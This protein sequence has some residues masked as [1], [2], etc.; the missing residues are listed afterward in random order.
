VIH[1][2]HRWDLELGHHARGRVGR[3]EHRLQRATLPEDRALG[4]SAKA[5]TFRTYTVIYKITEDL[6]AAMLGMLEP[7]EVEESVGM[8]EVRET[9]RASRIASS[10]AAQRD[11]GKDFEECQMRLVRDRTIVLE[12]T[13]ASLKRSGR[14]ARSREGFLEIFP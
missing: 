2:A 1:T 11:S 3:R 14:C 9:F 7:E 10:Q 6:R 12:G 5:S 8:A 13:L 4:R